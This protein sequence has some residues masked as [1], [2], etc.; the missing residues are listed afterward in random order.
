MAWINTCDNPLIENTGKWEL[1]LLPGATAHPMAPAVNPMHRHSAIPAALLLAAI[2]SPAGAARAAALR[3]EVKRL[4]SLRGAALKP[5]PTGEAKYSMPPFAIGQCIVCHVSNDP[6]K[7]GPIKH[8]TINEECFSCHDDVKEVMARPYKH[9]TKDTCTDCHNPHNSREPAL[10]HSE[11]VALCTSCHVGI[12]A[13]MAAAKVKHFALTKDKK[14]ANCHNPHASNIERVLIALPF[15]LCVNCHSRDGMAS[16]DGKPMPNYTKLLADNPVWHDPVKA[17]DCS[18]CHRTH[19][20]EYYRLL[21][22]NY[23]E[24]FYAPFEKKTYALCFGCHNEKVVSEAVTTA[25]TG[26]RDGSKNLHYTHVVR[27]RGRTCRAC[28]EVHAAKQAKRIRENVPYGPAGWLLNIGFTRTATGGTCIR[29]CHESK[30]YNNKVLT[31]AAPSGGVRA[32]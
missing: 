17:K 23:P 28:H 14:C 9:S 16:A 7:P 1:D 19:G 25:L 24:T 8:A 21:V 4:P 3:S 22:N 11:Q 5:I 20:G 10:L 32:E 30:S 18:A 2:L 31:S 13:Q 6:K 12:G 26:F 29:T 27:E 15:N